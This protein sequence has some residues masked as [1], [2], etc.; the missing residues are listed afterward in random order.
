QRS[1][2]EGESIQGTHRIWA[3]HTVALVPNR[4]RSTQLHC[5]D[6]WEQFDCSSPRRFSWKGLNDRSWSNSTNLPVQCPVGAASPVP[7]TFT[8]PQTIQVYLAPGAQLRVGV[9]ATLPTK[10]YATM[11]WGEAVTHSQVILPISGYSSVGPVEIRD[12]TG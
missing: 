12:W 5:V 1:A 6:V 9:N 4:I 11:Y 3:S 10:T 2:D 8:F 7:C